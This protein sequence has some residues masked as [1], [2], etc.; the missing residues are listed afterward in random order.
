MTF[1]L[2][3]VT[4][5]YDVARFT[6]LPFEAHMPPRLSALA[7]LLSLVA[8]GP[9]SQTTT[10]LTATGT[11]EVSVP[12]TRVRATFS[13]ASVGSSATGALSTNGPAAERLVLGLRAIPLTDSV[14]VQ[15]VGVDPNEDDSGRIRSYR[16]TTV[17]ELLIRNVDSV[18]PVLD[19]AVLLGLTSVD[20]IAFEAESTTQARHQALA[21]AFA[22]AQADADGL[23]MASGHRLG[24]L[25]SI[26]AD[27][28]RWRGAPFAFEEAS[29]TTG[30]SSAAFGNAQSGVIRIGPAPRQILVSA[31]VTGRWTLLQ[32]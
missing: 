23:A 1:Q 25:L 12:P 4:S 26:S 14:H 29:V 18:G 30:G 7:L 5:S 10:G 16:A 2:S 22:R 11:G 31:T 9:T 28:D 19:R 13:L 20:R 15:S 24:T 6:L 3:G 21:H 32:P 17:V 8:C 27:P